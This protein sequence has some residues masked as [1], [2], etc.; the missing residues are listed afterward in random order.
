MLALSW[1]N[2]TEGAK[3]H[4]CCYRL[5]QISGWIRQLF[6]HV[7]DRIGR[8]YGKGAVEHPDQESDPVVPAHGVVLAE[9]PPD[10]RAGS[11]HLWHRGDYDDGHDPTDDDKEQSDLV[12]DGQQAVPEDDKRGAGPGDEDESD[13]DVPWLDHQVRVVDGVHLH[14]DVG[15]DGHD[16]SE[17]EHPAEEVERA[18][19]EA[20]DAAVAGAGRHGGPVVDA[21]GG[22]DGGCE[23][24]ERRHGI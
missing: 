4:L 23:L 6:R 5:R 16:G 14:H 8:P 9:V 24:H 1:G 10:G 13:V 18:G 20:E 15:G 7:G 19:E 3:D 22:G 17:V 12:Q 11:V 21:A 2:H